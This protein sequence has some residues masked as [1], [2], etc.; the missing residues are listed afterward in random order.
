MPSGWG[1]IRPHAGVGRPEG[2]PRHQDS[3]GS[4]TYARSTTNFQVQRLPAPV[5]AAAKGPP[6]RVRP[7]TRHQASNGQRVAKGISYLVGGPRGMWTEGKIARR[8]VIFTS[9]R[10]APASGTR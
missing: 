3:P 4:R 1:E 7:Q 6:T 5:P 10:K 2:A 8:R 9:R